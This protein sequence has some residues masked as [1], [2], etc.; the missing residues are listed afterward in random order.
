[1]SLL[2]L[3]AL[4]AVSPVAQ[5]STAT[6]A[7]GCGRTVTPGSTTQTIAVG[8]ASR[9]YL[10][11]VPT[12]VVAG[13]P[14]P[15][16]MAL[17]G[18]SDTAQNAQRYMGLGGQRPAIYVYAQAPYWPEAGGVG[19]NVDPA[20]VDLPYFDALLADL[21]NKHCVDS[22]RVFATGKSNGAFMVNALAC[23]RP[24]M[25]RA[26]APVAGGGPQGSRCTGTTTRGPAAMIVHGAA[27]T[28]VPLRSGQFTR[29]YWLARNGN[30]GAAPTPTAPAPCVRYPGAVVPVL[31]CQHTGGHTWPSW[32]GPGVTNFFL[33]F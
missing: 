27:D 20:G 1:M 4:I 11:V 32:T 3:A 25:L 31:W 33:S 22:T 15:V 28:V 9:S 7:P 24:G 2:C 14:T 18:G 21:R 6:T 8:A 5:A 13:T 16:I 23:L 10:L 17:H 29:D 19:W 30:T 12:G 26:I